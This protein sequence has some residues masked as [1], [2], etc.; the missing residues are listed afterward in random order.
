VITDT[1]QPY[2]QRYPLMVETQQQYKQIIL[3]Q[4]VDQS[5]SVVSYRNLFDAYAIM[6]RNVNTS[7]Y[8]ATN[9]NHIDAFVYHHSLVTQV[10]NGI[11]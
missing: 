7:L 6:Y 5:F 1:N 8:T 10:M 2:R 4:F 11:R 3:R 9:F